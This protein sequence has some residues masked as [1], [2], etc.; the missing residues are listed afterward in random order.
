MTTDGQVW[1]STSRGCFVVGMVVAFSILG[2][3]PVAL[4]H[5]V[6]W[7]PLFADQEYC[8]LPEGSNLGRNLDRDAGDMLHLIPNEQ[9]CPPVWCADRDAPPGSVWRR[10]HSHRG[11]VEDGLF[12]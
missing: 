8:V 2:M 5:D 9:V 4:I 12:R 11:E 6:V 7:A 1:G 3:F 10:R